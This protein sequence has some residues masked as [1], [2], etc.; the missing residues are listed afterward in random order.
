M[1]IVGAAIEAIM[2]AQL[3]KSHPYIGLHGLDDVTEMQWA[4]GV[5]QGAGDENFAGHG[6]RLA[7]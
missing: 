1:G 3:L 7:I 2:T 4:I 5:G 6:S